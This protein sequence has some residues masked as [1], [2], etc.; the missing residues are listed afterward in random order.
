[1]RKIADGKHDTTTATIDAPAVLGEIDQQEIGY[2]RTT[3][4]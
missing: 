1:M 2:A 4:E 3:T